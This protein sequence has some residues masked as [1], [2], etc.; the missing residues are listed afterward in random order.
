MTGGVSQQKGGDFRDCS[1]EEKCR[2][3][4]FRKVKD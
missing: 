4:R 3:E 2:A 1:D